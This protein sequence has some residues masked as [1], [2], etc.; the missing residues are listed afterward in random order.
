VPSEV[1]MSD[2]KIDLISKD[3]EFVKDIVQDTSRRVSSLEASTSSFVKDFNE[4]IATDRQMSTEMSR[5]GRILEKNTDSLI[6]HMRR[7][8]INE[9]SIN[10]LKNIS[11]KI[12]ERL[13]PLEK[14]Y[15][16]RNTI[17][18]MAAK[19]GAFIGGLIGLVSLAYEILRSKP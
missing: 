13:Q 2:D 15:S 12:D 3:I 5:I 1:V 8:E 16:E 4:H 7:T 9:L 6:E 10:E 19:I 18:K 11:L 14:S 17:I